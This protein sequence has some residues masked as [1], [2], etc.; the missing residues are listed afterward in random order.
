M[1]ADEHVQGQ[2]ARSLPLAGCLFQIADVAAEPA[3][4]QQP[5]VRPDRRAIPRAICP[6]APSITGRANGSKSPTRL[7][8]GK[9]VCGLMPRRRG[10]AFAVANRAQRVRAAQMAGNDP[11]ILRPNNSAVASGDIAMAGA[12]KAPTLHL[13]LFGPIPGNRVVADC[14]RES[15]GESRFRTPP[16]AEFRA[17]F[18]LSRRMAAM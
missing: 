12:V 3:D 8:C 10:H 1:P 17:S 5:P 2:R 13:V 14:G 4:A 16:P 11:Q 7:L 6:F 15:S 18:S 9:P